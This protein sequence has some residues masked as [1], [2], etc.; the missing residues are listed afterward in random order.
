MKGRGHRCRVTSASIGRLDVGTHVLFDPIEA[1]MPSDADARLLE[2]IRSGSAE[3]GR[4]FV[5]EHYSAIY[6]YSVFGLQ[7]W[8]RLR[9]P[10]TEH[11]TPGAKRPRS[12]QWN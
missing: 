7:C 9:R 1:G 4:S 2:Q 3:A 10:K 8:V 5:Q 6:Q 11:R 12:Q